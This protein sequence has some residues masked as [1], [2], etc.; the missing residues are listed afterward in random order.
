MG[1][2]QK[3]K[4]KGRA[5][6]AAELTRE[7]AREEVR[8]PARRRRRAAAAPQRRLAHPTVVSSSLRHNQAVWKG[9]PRLAGPARSLQLLALEAIFGEDITLREDGAALGFALRVVPHPGAARRPA[10]P[11]AC[12]P[13][14]VLSGRGSTRLRQCT[15]QS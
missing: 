6:A 4:Q 9:P 12:L 3:K 2:K 13:G 7:E 11:H 5:A 10:C 1:K 14:S 15:A 8:S